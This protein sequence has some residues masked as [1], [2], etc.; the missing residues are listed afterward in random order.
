MRDPNIMNHTDEIYEQ[1]GKTILD[2]PSVPK[3]DMEQ[4]DLF[5]DKDFKKY[6]MDIEKACRTSF[7]YRQFINY[8]RTDEGMDHCSVLEHASARDNSKVKIEL[9]HSPLTLFDICYTVYA[10]RQ[11]NREDLKV[12]S[13]AEEVIYLHYL[14]WVGL[15]PLSKTIHDL[16]HNQYLFI[17]NDKVRGNYRMF[18]REYYN[19]ID[20]ETLDCYD[21]TEQATLDYLQKYGNQMDLLNRHEL[22]INAEGSYDLPK[23]NDMQALVK[24]RVADIKNEG[25]LMAKVINK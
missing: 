13:V 16:V 9:H 25:V 5:N 3:F 1:G 8:L 20:P 23:L 19:Y 6:M 4:Y 24:R 14:G 11:A 17:P 10:K 18:V 21:A 7:E 22:Y 15:I 12:E 2:I